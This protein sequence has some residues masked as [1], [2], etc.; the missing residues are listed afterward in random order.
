MLYSIASAPTTNGDKAESRF[1]HR[2]SYCRD[3]YM[4]NYILSE[5]WNLKTGKQSLRNQNRNFVD[6]S[7]VDGNHH[8]QNYAPASHVYQN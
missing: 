6:Q 8:S 4:T 7:W 3:C 5:R 1:M 2:D